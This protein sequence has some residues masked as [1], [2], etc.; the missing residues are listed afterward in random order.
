MFDFDILALFWLEFMSV[1]FMFFIF[2]FLLFASLP[3]LFWLSLARSLIR[4]LYLLSLELNFNLVIP[5][6]E[7]CAQILLTLTILFHLFGLDGMS[8]LEMSFHDLL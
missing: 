7:K 6:L 4:I 3:L 8:K 2:L 5:Y 1:F